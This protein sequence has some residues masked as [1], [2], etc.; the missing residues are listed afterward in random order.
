MLLDL[1][2]LLLRCSLAL[3]QKA[4]M[5]FQTLAQLRCLPAGL[6]RAQADFLLGRLGSVHLFG[7]LHHPSITRGQGSAKVNSQEGLCWLRVLPRKRM[8]PKGDSS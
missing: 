8:A 4:L 3:V 1:A 5:Q 6:L 7:D 2:V